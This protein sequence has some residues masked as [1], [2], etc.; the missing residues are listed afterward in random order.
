MTELSWP[1]GKQCTFDSS[2]ELLRELFER[3]SNDWIYRGQANFDWPISS[4]LSR[5]L[6]QQAKNGGPIGQDLFTCKAVCPKRD[7]HALMVEQLLLR[8]FILQAEGLSIANLPP[9]QD[10]LG[11]WELMQHHGVPTRLLDWSRSPFVALWF[12]INDP[13]VVEKVDASITVL[14]VHNIWLA[15]A[16]WILE[17]ETRHVSWSEFRNDRVQQ[18]HWAERLIKSDNALVPLEI[19]PRH[20]APR[21][22]AQ[23]SIMTLMPRI[24]ECSSNYLAERLSTKI[25]ICAEWKPELR[26]RCE[27]QGITR[28]SLYRDLDTLGRELGNQLGNNNLIAQ[29]EAAIRELHRMQSEFQRNS[30]RETEENE[31]A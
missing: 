30:P 17:E 21:V 31:G 2:S 18:N 13:D 9:Y 27:D 20:P 4:T 29:P 16:Q 11:W 1:R 8:E 28:F 3:D 14:N 7:D 15:H 12:A 25:R 5:A 22:V 6:I 10:R 24:T 26:Q 23:Q 19:S